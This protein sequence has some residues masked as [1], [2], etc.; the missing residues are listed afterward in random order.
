MSGLR[1]LSFWID[2][3]ERGVRAYA[4]GVITAFSLGVPFLGGLS[5]PW[6]VALIAGAVYSALSVITCIASLVLPY[7]DRDTGS[8][9][10]IP[11]FQ[12]LTLR[13]WVRQLSCRTPADRRNRPTGER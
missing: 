3:G 2:T 4:Q 13:G 9:L 12:L 5:V 7:S 10:A 11:P 8:F 1:S 6:R